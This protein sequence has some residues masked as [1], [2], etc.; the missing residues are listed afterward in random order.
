MQT[1][2]NFDTLFVESTFVDS[3]FV[4]KSYEN[5]FRSH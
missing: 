4:K 3:F 5:I 1:K 2:T